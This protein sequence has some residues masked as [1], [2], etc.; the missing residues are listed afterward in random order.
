MQKHLNICLM[1]AQY[2]LKST[3][4]KKVKNVLLI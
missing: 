1:K 4:I 2:Y 3:R